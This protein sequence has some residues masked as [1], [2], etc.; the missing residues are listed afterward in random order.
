LRDCTARYVKLAAK[1][2]LPKVIIE[3]LRR[4]RSYAG[5]ERALYLRLRALD[6]VGITHPKERQAPRTARR[7]LFVCHGNIMRSP[8]CE[9]LMKRAVRSCNGEF[10]IVSAG[11]NA[12]PGRAVHPWAVRAGNELGVCL[13]N[14]YAQPVTAEMVRKAEVIF[15]MDYQNMVQLQ[16]RYPEAK[17]KLFMLGAYGRRNDRSLEISDP[18]YSGEEGTRHCFMILESCISN[19]VSNLLD[20]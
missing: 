9:A 11:L 13:G 18:Y 20:N 14:H 12:I 5:A 17:N 6:A 2:L 15:A 8:M 4:Y 16:S 10:S 7:F 1:N 19:L 3:E